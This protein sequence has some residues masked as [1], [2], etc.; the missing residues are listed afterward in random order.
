MSA[1]YHHQNIVL[2]S[3]CKQQKIPSDDRMMEIILFAQMENEILKVKDVRFIRKPR[4]TTEEK[5]K[6]FIEHVDKESFSLFPDS[7]QFPDGTSVKNWFLNHKEEFNQYV[8]QSLTL[9][10]EGHVLEYLEMVKEEKQKLKIRDNRRFS[11]QLLATT[12]LQN[13]E[14]KVKRERKNESKI[15]DLRMGELY[16]LALLDDYLYTLERTSPL[17]LPVD[18]THWVKRIKSSN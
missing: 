4:L 11:D 6:Y 17:N 12:W 7:F 2:R 14:Q 8:N 5:K 9:S 10:L 16:T 3:E 18:T 15:S 1:W 13:Q